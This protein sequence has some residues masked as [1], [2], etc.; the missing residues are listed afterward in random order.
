[1]PNLWRLRL[2]LS[3]PGIGA[4]NAYALK[5]DDGGLVLVDCGGS[6]D[7]TTWA[8]LE[9]AVRDS[10][11]E[12]HDVREVVITHYHSD[13]AGP[14]EQVVARSGAQVLAHPAHA[15]LT[16]GAERPEE[17]AAVRRRRAIAEGVPAEKLHLFDDM[18]EETEG[19]DSP[20]R[21]D[22]PLLEGDVITTV[23]GDWRVMETPG[24][25]PSHLCLY[26]PESGTLI[27]GDLLSAE[28]HPWFDYGYTADPVQETF[29]SLDRLLGLPAPSLALPG[30]GRPLE[31]VHDLAKMH[32]QRIG[33]RLQAV[34]DSVAGGGGTA[35]E[36]TLAV[37]GEDPTDI[38]LVLRFTETVSYL[39][40][41]R[42]RGRI[43]RNRDP[44]GTF[45][46]SLIGQARARRRPD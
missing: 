17:I 36:I 21:P 20:V 18:R 29:D 30:H 34:R 33:E 45:R 22:R 3:W 26:Q 28:F 16:D 13:H 35:Y 19:I 41:D 4:T 12:I 39:G 25:A 5:R 40:H 42:R 9:R 14:L 44:D 23:H 38:E 32:V 2:P 24:H 6:G 8:A 11:H 31:S 27:V 43:Q 1:M 46:H 37:F 10:G 15:H 7:P